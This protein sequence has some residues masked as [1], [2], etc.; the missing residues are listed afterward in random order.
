MLAFTLMRQ[1]P[2][3]ICE[4]ESKPGLRPQSKTSRAVNRGRLKKKKK[5]DC[6]APVASEYAF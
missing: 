6:W 1:G 3:D 5:K 2:V 4:F